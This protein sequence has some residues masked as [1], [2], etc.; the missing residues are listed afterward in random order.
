MDLQSRSRARHCATKKVTNDVS[1][2]QVGVRLDSVDSKWVVQAKSDG[3]AVSRLPN[4]ESWEQLLLE[5]KALW[6]KYVDV[7]KPEAVVRL[8]VRY[9]NR[10]PLPGTDE[11]DIDTVL[12]SGPK[13]PSTLPQVIDEF[14]SRV[15]LPL[16]DKKIRLAIAQALPPVS[17][18]SAVPLGHVVLDID[19]SSEEALA[20][21]APEVWEKLEALRDAKNM[22]FFGSVTESTWRSF[23]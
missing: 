1:N 11:V 16:E 4:Y 23:L 9:I 2:S 13:I 12:T 8:G 18:G 19:A 20:P 21:S 15:V 14:V 5:V 3:L 22:A 17:A 7:F 10:L 6:P